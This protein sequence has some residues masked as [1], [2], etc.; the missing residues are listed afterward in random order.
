[1]LLMF[2]LSLLLAVI[3]GVSW[4]LS[5]RSPARGGWADRLTIGE[6]GRLRVVDLKTIEWIESQGNYQAL[7][8]QDAVHLYRETSKGLEAMLDPVR[9]VRI[10]RRF[11]V[12][13]DQ[14][15]EV[16]PLPNGDAIVRLASGVEL[17]QSRHHR[18]PFRAR[19]L[20]AR[21]RA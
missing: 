6:R 13:A 1:V 10:H 15:R 11:I 2:C 5:A 20:E 19:L 18:G 4:A 8:A 21:A 7:H 16:E 17:R 12:A 9:F 3:Q 14:V